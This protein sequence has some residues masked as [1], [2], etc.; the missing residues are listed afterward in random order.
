MAR[1]SSTK[2]RLSNS[3][4]QGTVQYV[5]FFAL[6]G[7]SVQIV[8]G[9]HFNTPDGEFVELKSGT[10]YEILLKNSHPYGKVG[11]LWLH[12]HCRSVKVRNGKIKGVT[13][14]IVILVVIDTVLVVMIDVMKKMV[15]P[16]VLSR[17]NEVEN[18]TANV[19]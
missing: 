9:K 5:N 16:Q 15:D 1:Q 18:E 13:I 2:P 19:R 10:Q 11:L 7:Y 8:G 14:T 4:G 17:R 6:E 3:E 12:M